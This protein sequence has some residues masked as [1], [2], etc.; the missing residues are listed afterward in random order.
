MFTIGSG[1]LGRIFWD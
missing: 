1:S